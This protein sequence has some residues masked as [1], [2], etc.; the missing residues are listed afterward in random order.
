MGVISLIAMISKPLV[1]KERT[2]A[3]RPL[4]APLIKTFTWLGPVLDNFSTTAAA[5]FEAA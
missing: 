4:P 5:T 3:S 1:T 2:A